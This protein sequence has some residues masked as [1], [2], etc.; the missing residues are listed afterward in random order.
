MTNI[1]ALDA[2]RAA[3][4]A[5]DTVTRQAASDMGTAG[6]DFSSYL[7]TDKNLEDIYAEASQTYG[8][9]TELL[10]AMTKQE[11][12]FNPNATSRS[13]AQGLMQLM[14]A[15]AASLGV[16]NAY[17]PYQ[18]IMGGAKYIRQMLDKY[19]GD[20]SLA[21]AAYNA[22]SNNVDKYGGIP[23]F[24]ETQNYVAKITQYL[25]EGITVPNTDTVYAAESTV[26]DDRSVTYQDLNQL[27][28][29]ILTEIFSYDDYMKYLSSLL[30]KEETSLALTLSVTSAAS[31]EEDEEEEE[32]LPDS[33]LAYQ[34]LAVGQTPVSPAAANVESDI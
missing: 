29:E 33:V 23:P 14:P 17:D 26:N 28:G 32:I 2:L 27:A 10:K 18:N 24:A 11:S 5:S 30:G 7:K 1:S 20:V 4:A 22:G 15:T 21:L 25:Q 16:T 12:N 19:N 13:G 31:D 6:V 34:D 9:S 3:V 8:V